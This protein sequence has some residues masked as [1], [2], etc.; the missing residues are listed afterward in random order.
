MVK[1][2]DLIVTPEDCNVY[3]N[4][5][6]TKIGVNGPMAA[7]AAAAEARRIFNALRVRCR[8]KDCPV[9]RK[10]MSVG[11]P[12]VNQIIINLPFGGTVTIALGWAC[13]YEIIYGCFRQSDSE[14]A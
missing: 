5:F 12:R 9:P 7:A 2:D 3:E 10:G 1:L 6:G 13:D 11:K 4:I 14:P 8:N